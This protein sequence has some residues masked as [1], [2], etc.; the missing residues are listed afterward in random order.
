MIDYDDIFKN[1][2]HSG[3]EMEKKPFMELQIVTEKEAIEFEAEIAKSKMGE[4]RVDDI[5]QK[6]VGFIVESDDTARE[7]LSIALSARKMNKDIS[8]LRKEITAPALR[9]QK[10][11]IQIEKELTD[12]LTTLESDL[13]EK[14]GRY[15]TNREKTLEDAGIIDEDFNNLKTELGSSSIKSYYEFKIED[16]EKIPLKYLKLDEK[17]L[18]EDIKNGIRNVPGINIF[19]VKKR[20]YRLRSKK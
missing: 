5:V 18:K 6:G 1:M 2:D 20:Q 19:E 7:A 17:K 14:I 8:K 16:I 12:K 11:A 9:F 15:Q 3:D 4:D 13:L 10:K